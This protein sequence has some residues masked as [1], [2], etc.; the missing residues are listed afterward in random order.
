MG[1]K[2][3]LGALGYI[4]PTFIWG[5]LWHLVFFP[6]VY[7]TFG[8]YTRKNPIILMGL[9]SMIVQGIILAWVYSLTSGPRSAHPMRSAITFNLVIG[10]FFISGTV[11]ALAAKAEIAHLTAWFGYNLAFSA[12]Q[13]L[14]SGIAFGLV[15]R[16]KTA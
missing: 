2:I 11:L 15:F 6:D 4:V 8:V 3:A 1:K 9:G 16:G 12:V 10:L 14:M 13:F 7:E 5:Y